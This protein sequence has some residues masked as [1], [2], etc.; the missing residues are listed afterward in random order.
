MCRLRFEDTNRAL[1]QVSKY[2]HWSSRALHLPLSWGG[3]GVDEKCV[4]SLE[5][6]CRLRI[7]D[8]NRALDQVSKYKQQGP[9]TAPQLGER[10]RNEK[11]VCPF[12]FLS[13]LLF[14]P[15]VRWILLLILFLRIQASLFPSFF[16]PCSIL[17]SFV[18]APSQYSTG[19]VLVFSVAVP[20]S[21]A[22]TWKFRYPSQLFAYLWI[23]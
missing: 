3:G 2:N 12:L 18:S 9:P 22:K 8:T 10:W 11:C 14:F 6:M 23:W 13:L 15:L 17:N 16:R 1:D 7:E 19:T 20:T 4:D 5:V 21:F